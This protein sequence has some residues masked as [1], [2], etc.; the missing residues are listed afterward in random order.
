MEKP[1]YDNFRFQVIKLSCI[2]EYSP[3]TAPKNKGG[4]SESQYFK[5]VLS[6]A[7]KFDSL[8][9]SDNWLVE[10]Y[11]VIFIIVK[12]IFTHEKANFHGNGSSNDTF[13]RNYYLYIDLH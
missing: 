4:Y 3:F 11:T 1:H 13:N 7:S 5:C 9:Q 10:N 6:T 8:A 12:V 2:P